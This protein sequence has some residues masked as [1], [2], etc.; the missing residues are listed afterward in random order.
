MDNQPYTELFEYILTQQIPSYFSKEQKQQL[1]K[2][3]KDYIVEN[4]LL[5]KMDKNDIT[6]LYRVI[7][8]EELPALLYMMHNDPTSGHF[9]T[10]AMFTKIKTRYYWPQ[11]YEDIKKYVESCDACQRRG[12]SKKTIYYTQFQYT[13]PFIK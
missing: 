8:R 4:D 2:Q 3:A 5:Y 9:A 11:Y 1:Q 7:Q 10:D 6:K 12:R 13:A